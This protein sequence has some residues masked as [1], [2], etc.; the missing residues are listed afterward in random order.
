MSSSDARVESG[1]RWQSLRWRLPL[2]IG[3]VSVAVLTL[4]LYAAYR[5]VEATLL[6]TGAERARHAAD[7]VSGL[8]GRSTR[9]SFDQLRQVAPTL[10]EYLRDPTDRHLASAQQAL[11]PL[12]AGPNRH[13]TV[14]NAAGTRMFDLPMVPVNDDKPDLGSVAPLAAPPELGF[15]FIRV[16]GNRFFTDVGVAVPEPGS[17]KRLGVVAIRSGLSVSPADLLNRLV[18]VDARILLGNRRGDVWTDLTRAV[19]GPEV[20]LPTDGAKEYRTRDGD[21]R[22]GALSGVP[23]APWV[24]WVEFPRAAIL[25]PATRFLQRMIYLGLVMAIATTVLVRWLTIRVTTPLATMTTAAE[26]MA[27]GDYSRRVEGGRA[28]EIGR[29]GRAFNAMTEQVDSARTVLEDRVSE[30]TAQLNA[31][32]S[33][34]HERSR[35]REAYLATIVESS[36]DAIIGKDLDGNI[37]SWNKGAV[38]ILGYTAGEMIGTSIMRLIPEDRHD[39]ERHILEQIR[40]GQRLNH[41]ETRRLTRDGRLIDVSLTS[42]PITGADGTVVGGSTVLRDVSEYN[43]AEAARRTSESRYRT[44]FDYAPD[45]I[46]ISDAQGIYLDVNARLCEMLGYTRDE[47]IGMDASRIVVRSELAHVQPALDTIVKTA[48]YHREWQLQRKDGSVF[49]ADVIGTLMPDGNPLAMVRDVTERDAAAAAVRSAEERMRFA[50]EAAGVG[51]WDMD[52]ESGALKW[53]ESFVLH[54][55]LKRGVAGGAVEDV[56][57]RIHPQDRETVVHAMRSVNQAATEFTLE[58]RA[59]WP[60]GMI[61]WLN[62]AGRIIVGQHGEPVRAVGVSLDVTARHILEAQL[63][64]SQKMEAVGQLAGGVAHDFNNLLTAVLGFSRLVRDSLDEDDPRIADI[65]EVIQAGVRATALTKQLLAFSRKEVIKPVAVDVNS[66][67]ENTHTMLRR[68]I[69]EDIEVVLALGSGVAP[70]YAD[71]GQLDQVLMNLAVN[72]RDA[73][74]NGGR[75][76]IETANVDLDASFGSKHGPVEAGSYVMLAVS[77]TGIGMTEEVRARLFEPFFTTKERGRGTGLGLSTVFGIVKQNGGYVYVYSEPE[78]GATF[79]IYFPR[80]VAGAPNVVLRSGMSI[81][82]GSETVLLVEDEE[83]VRLLVR[84]ILQ[85]MGYRVLVAGNPPEAEALF[86]RY[87]QEIDGLITDVIMPGGSG[88]TLFESLSRTKPNLRVL[89]M[90]GYTDDAMFRRGRLG[91]GVTFLQKPFAAE[92]LL[93]TLREVLDAPPGSLPSGSLP[94]A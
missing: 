32:V 59:I 78:H 16:A 33:K 36:G 38:E 46:I 44:L 68:L 88:P 58:Y 83:A 92:A 4:V 54:H 61:R 6:Q 81:P 27:A 77:D 75:L 65:D 24:V 52:F 69:G 91:E 50:L 64:Q 40:K 70:I 84:L 80:L 29:L 86:A 22:L 93:R 43:R 51:I 12:A 31:A 39:E 18:G 20:D 45:G 87:G 94:A 37:T 56:I 35:D 25:S 74:P 14:W 82:P 10:S 73:M 1:S 28:D 2:L 15:G 3:A 85:N 9:Q 79:K 89:Y 62:G 17:S 5:E 41:F 55:G 23:G 49:V 11:V 67:I 19:P 30:R 63:Q 47:L 26:A 57:E 34:L 72:A 90:S 13:I 48:D 53:S 7:Q 21:R 60:D 76:T 42:S 8:F 66:L 71:P